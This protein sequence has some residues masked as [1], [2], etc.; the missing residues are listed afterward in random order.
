GGF[1]LSASRWL[2]WAAL[3]SDHLEVLAYG[4]VIDTGRMRT[5]LGFSPAYTT[6]GAFESYLA[7][8]RAGDRPEQQADQEQQGVSRCSKATSSRPS[9][10][11]FRGC[12]PPE[13]PRGWPG[14][15]WTSRWPAPWH[16]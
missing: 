9:W 14:R 12:G 15:N 3:P 4:R 6:R 13:P 16:S 8:S 11:S 1:S 2:G 5:A 10:C 7:A